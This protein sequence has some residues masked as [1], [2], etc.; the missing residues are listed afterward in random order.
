MALRS[1]AMT[2]LV[3]YLGVTKLMSLALNKCEKT[4]TGEIHV[5]VI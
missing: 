4:V 3:S 2:K 1:V 5:T